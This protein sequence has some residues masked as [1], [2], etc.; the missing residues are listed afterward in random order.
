MHE[1]MQPRQR[2]QYIKRSVKGGEKGGDTGRG[3][4]G[5]V[6]DGGGYRRNVA[7]ITHC[8]VSNHPGIKETWAWG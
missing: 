7:N 4:G 6:K 2:E 3:G 1:G 8:D 5:G